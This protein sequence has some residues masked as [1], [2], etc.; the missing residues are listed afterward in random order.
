MTVSMPLAM[1]KNGESCRI[2][3]VCAGQNLKRRLVEMGMTPSATVRLVG[4]RNGGSLLVNVNGVRYAIG[5]GMAMKI[6][7]QPLLGEVA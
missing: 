2:N 7:V 6:K 3:D 5:R 4:A 1:L